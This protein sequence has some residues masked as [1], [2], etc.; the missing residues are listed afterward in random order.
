[1]IAPPGPNWGC[2]GGAPRPP[3]P[4]PGRTAGSA[5]ARAESTQVTG[6]N[7]EFKIRGQGFFGVDNGI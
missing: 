2:R 6:F 7:K 3:G 5:L 1:M 4:G